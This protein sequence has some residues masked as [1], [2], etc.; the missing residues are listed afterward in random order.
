MLWTIWKWEGETPHLGNRC[1]LEDDSK[2]NLTKRR[3][4]SVNL[5][6]VSYDKDQWQALVLLWTWWWTCMK[7]IAFWDTGS[8]SLL[9]DCTVLCSR[10]LSSSYLLQWE[11][12][13]SHEPSWWNRWK[14]YWLAEQLL[15]SQGILHHLVYVMKYICMYTHARMH[16]CTY[17]W[18][19]GCL[20]TNKQT[21]KQ[22]K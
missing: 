6:H 7:I 15:A 9:W 21:N 18:T 10:R 22:T 16:A 12:E 8:C 17:T 11:P 3:Q 5:I 20:Q 2:T 19:H 1:R 13:I 14:I 4:E